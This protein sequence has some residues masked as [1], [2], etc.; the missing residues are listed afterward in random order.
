VLL[1]AVIPMTGSR[2]VEP[3][4]SLTY[5]LLVFPNKKKPLPEIIGHLEAR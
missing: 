2:T 3:G 4:T 5:R 1:Q